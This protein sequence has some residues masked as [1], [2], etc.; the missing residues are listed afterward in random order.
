MQKNES[1]KS[2]KEIV[3]EYIEA[4][5]R[6]DFRTARGYI[7]DN[8]SVVGP[9]PGPSGV[10]TINGVDPFIKYLEHADLPKLDIK[11][12]FADSQDVCLLYEMHYR[13]PAVTTFVCGLFHV[14]DEGKIASMRFVVDPRALFDQKKQAG[15]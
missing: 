13:S 12:E 9:G 4:L 8:I 11:K 2:T 6:K 5:E 3:M 14:N 10:Q 7:T 1:R 15:A